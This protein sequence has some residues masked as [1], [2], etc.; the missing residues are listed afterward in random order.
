MQQPASKRMKPE[1]VPPVQYKWVD[2]DKF[3]E[4]ILSRNPHKS[5]AKILAR[6]EELKKNCPVE[7][8]DIDGNK[9]I[10]VKMAYC[11]K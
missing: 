5:P 7:E 3:A 10:F 2:F 1:A 11:E 8:R 4:H 9:V 6:W